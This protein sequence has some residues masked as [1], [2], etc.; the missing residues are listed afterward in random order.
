MV[1]T[2][3][4]Q[5]DGFI[6]ITAVGGETELDGDFPI[7]EKSHV[8]IIR[9]RG[10]VDTTLVLNTD[11]TIADN[12]LEVTA[13]FTAVLAGSST[14]AVAGD[15]YTLL[16]A[17]PEA[18]TTDFSEAGDYKAATVNRELDLFQQQVQQLRRDVDKSARL[19][20]TSA[21]T[22]VTLP[23][24][25]ANRVIGWN[26]DGDELENYVINDSNYFSVTPFIETLLDDTTAANART[27][28]GA[29]GLT[30]NETIAG[31]KTFSSAITTNG[32]IVFPASQNASANANTLDD[33]EEGDWTPTLTF[34]TAGNLSVSYTTRT[35]TYTK[36][37][38]MI[39]RSVNILTSAFTHTT[40]S[41][42]MIVSGSPFTSV[43]NSGV[44]SP[45]FEGISKAGYTH[46]SVRS[47]GAASDV[48][49]ASGMGVGYAAVNAADAP[50]GGTIGL[51]YTITE[52]V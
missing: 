17:V 21:L 37:G 10:G 11:Y 9:T 33:Y 24:P 45:A 12:Q 18:R 26:A 4:N 34:A 13:G 30:G 3:I 41:G 16:L 51:R 28:L 52:H 5:N 36:I 50:T 39:T 8:S 6:Q 15:V 49:A 40:A 22:V 25:T 43:V 27:T 44:V 48:V 20:D 42:Q 7:Y 31:A 32:Q 19:P 35:G 38:R 2:V 23:T 1:E 46:V 14:P 29:V 47:S